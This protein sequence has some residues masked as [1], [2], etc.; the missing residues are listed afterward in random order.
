[1]NKVSGLRFREE[2]QRGF[3]ILTNGKIESAATTIK[4]EK[5]NKSGPVAAWNKVLHNANYHERL[6]EQLQKLK[7]EEYY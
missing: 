4:M 3:D 7:E 6:Q 2:T 1:M 5:V